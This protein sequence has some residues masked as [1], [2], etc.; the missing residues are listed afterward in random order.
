MNEEP[1]LKPT[2]SISYIAPN[3]SEDSTELSKL[4]LQHATRKPVK[5]NMRIL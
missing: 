3:K 4:L 5:R 1:R 2:A